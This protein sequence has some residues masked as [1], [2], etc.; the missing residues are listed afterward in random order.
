MAELVRQRAARI[1]LVNK[2]D[3][4][5]SLVITIKQPPVLGY[6]QFSINLSRHDT[7]QVAI[8]KYLSNVTISAWRMLENVAT[9]IAEAAAI[10]QPL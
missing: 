2:L 4:K 1:G 9:W 6:N 3:K 10:F 7:A 8:V 5:K